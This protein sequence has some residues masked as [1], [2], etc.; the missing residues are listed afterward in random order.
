MNN[1]PYFNQNC[2]PNEINLIFRM[3]LCLLSE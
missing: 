1:M 3:V 2:M